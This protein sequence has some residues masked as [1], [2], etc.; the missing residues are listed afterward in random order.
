MRKGILELCILSIISE[1]EE[2]YPT[3]IINRLKGSEMPV[4]DGTMYPLLNRLK[5]T[6]LLQYTWRESTTG[7]PRKYY[8]LTEDGAEFL[9]GLMKEWN[10]ILTVLH[11]STQNLTIKK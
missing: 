6:G 1:G 2:V 8:R 11:H 5:E 7:P 9:D 10:R 3:D 4:K